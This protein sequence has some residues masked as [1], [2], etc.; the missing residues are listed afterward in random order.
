MII[1]PN[2]VFVAVPRTGGKTVANWLV[3]SFREPGVGGSFKEGLHCG[4]AS[5]QEA[6]ISTEF[7]SFCFIRNP[8]DR[9]VSTCAQFDPNFSCD[10]AESMW[11]LLRSPFNFLTRPQSVVSYGVSLKIP[12]E[13]LEEAPSILSQ[14]FNLTSNIPL[15]H[16][17]KS[18]HLSFSDYA[19]RGLLKFAKKLYQNDIILWESLN[20]SS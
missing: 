10:P 9:L 16:F 5:L 12:F 11:Q 20:A 13:K 6:E 14:R 17:H 1:L 15:Q 8:F 18:N 2:L 4:H 3:Q 7:P 19:D